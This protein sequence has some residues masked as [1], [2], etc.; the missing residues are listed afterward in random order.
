MKHIGFRSISLLLAVVLFTLAGCGATPSETGQLGAA[1]DVTEGDAAKETPFKGTTTERERLPRPAY[2]PPKQF[3]P[4][5]PTPDPI[6]LQAADAA[7]SGSLRVT[8]DGGVGM[9]EQKDPNDKLTFTVEIEREGFYRLEFESKSSGGYKENNVHIDGS[10]AGALVTD[11]MD[12]APSS[13]QHIY[14]TEG[15]HTVALTAVWGWIAVKSLTISPEEASDGSEFYVPIALTN[16]NADDNALGLMSYLAMNY[17]KTSLA[18]Q[19]SQGDWAN[20][21]GLFGG[22]AELIYEQ[23]GKR[24]AV[25]GLDMID[26]SPSRVANGTNSSEVEAAIEAWENNAIVTFCWHWNAP[27]DYITGT[28]WSAFYTEHVREGFFKKIMDGDDPAGY[29]MLVRDI[30]AIAEELAILRD[31]GVPVLWRPLHEASGGWF[32]WGTDR[33]SYLKLYELLYDRLTNHH[34]LTNL[35]WVWNGQH[36]D[37]YPGD[38]MVDIIGEDVY[39]EQRSYASQVNRFLTAESYTDAPKIITLSE[40]G[41]LFDPDLAARDG[42]RWSWWCVWNGDFVNSEDYTEL[43]MLKK[44]YDSELVTTHDE[45][46]DLKNYP[47]YVDGE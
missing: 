27:E 34:N 1:S 41:V 9:F 21:H 7:I 43:S 29:N 3:I 42:A 25:I 23:T 24:P 11:S 2:E 45:L 36:K 8:G 18:G 40:N 26:Y 33:T 46:P 35:I 30:D 5:G 15:T 16:P 19:Q 13:M 14:L 22:E 39:A 31:A 4:D 28:W 37:W 20:D 12:Y 32:W 44:V 10:P 47:I 17:G 38:D 6:T